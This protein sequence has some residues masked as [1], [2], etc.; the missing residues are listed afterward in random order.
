MGTTRGFDKD[1]SSVIMP[2]WLPMDNRDLD[3][4]CVSWSQVTELSLTEI[5]QVEV[6]CERDV[7]VEG[8]GEPLLP[9]STSTTGEA[10]NGGIDPQ[11]ITSKMYDF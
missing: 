11:V 4:A 2:S 5:F 10:R 7:G 8:Q 6:Q 1:A 3:T 9:R